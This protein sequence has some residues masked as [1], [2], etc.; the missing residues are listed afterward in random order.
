MDNLSDELM[1]TELGQLVAWLKKLLKMETAT[2]YEK[3]SEHLMSMCQIGHTDE[4]G[5]RQQNFDPRVYW[6]GSFLPSVCHCDACGQRTCGVCQCHVCTDNGQFNGMVLC[7]T[8]AKCRPAHKEAVAKRHQSFLPGTTRKWKDVAHS[9][10]EG[11]MD[12]QAKRVK[13]AAGWGFK[14]TLRACLEMEL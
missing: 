5:R 14:R 12:L 1:R 6:D 13:R 10:K 8:C 4:C 7:L 11:R 9:R 2:W 3:L